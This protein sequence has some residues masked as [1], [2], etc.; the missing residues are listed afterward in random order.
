MQ[1]RGLIFAAAFAT[2]VVPSLGRADLFQLTSGGELRGQLVN[3]KRLPT[4]D[5]VVTTGD[6]LKLTLPS[7][8]V[9][10]FVPKSDAQRQYETLL[11]RMPEG[12]DGNWK[13][14][15]WCA[16]QGLS[17]EREYHLQEVL[18]FEAD[19]KDARM[20]L[21]FTSLDGK[22]I[23]T[24]DY[25]RSR[26]FISHQG[27][28]LTPQDVETAKL[29]EAI[30]AAQREVKPNLKRWRKSLDGRDARAREAALDSIRH[31]KDPLA[32]AALAE[33]FDDE[34]RAD[35]RALWV[36]VIGQNPNPTAAD[37]LVK[38]A[39]D[40]ADANVR[41]KA[42]DQLDARKDR[43]AMG[44]LLGLLQSKD[45]AK[46]NRAAAALGR[47]GEPDAILPLIDALVTEH[48]FVVQR[49]SGGGGP[50][51]IGASFSPTG[52]SGLSAGGGPKV[53]KHQIQNQSALEALVTL[54]PQQKTNF[55]YDKVRWKEWYAKANTP[56]DVDLRREP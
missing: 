38:A 53:E 54:T 42:R 25:M 17:E 52:G 48:K 11:P 50:G 27:K 33:M 55:G 2:G 9:R 8:Q 3:V 16:T 41:E 32:M 6:G 14:A 31:V 46:V 49:G 56:D 15:Q 37:T 34:E 40:D 39:V 23:K 43:R 7:K 4:D 26:G 20:A 47:I 51:S 44:A 21:G 24:D 10:R 12:P 5:Y 28:W 35:Y 30:D 29:Q 18:R 19:H 22:W 1:I 45:N 36:E 13:M